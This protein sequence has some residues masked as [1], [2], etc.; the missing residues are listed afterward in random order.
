MPLL[1][2]LVAA[3]LLSASHS[4]GSI[5]YL[6]QKFY[7]EES[8]T[9]ISEYFN[10]IEVT[11][12]RVILRSDSNF[13]TGHYITFQLSSSNAVD[14]FKLEVYEFGAKDPTE[15]LFKPDSTI[16]PSKPIYLGL[17]GEKWT[18]KYQ[19]PVAYKLSLID[20][21]GKAILSATSFLW[22]DD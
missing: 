3:I 17:T 18:D 16:P 20:K 14:H 13:R 12:N 5:E 22:G 15:F 10:D 1:R 9:R 2:T 8:F 11:G 19:P 4:F 6:E 21:D 7:S